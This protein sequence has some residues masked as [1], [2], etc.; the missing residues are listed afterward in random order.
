V[1]VLAAK[2]QKSSKR[3]DIVLGITNGGIVPAI[4]MGRELEIDYI[5]FIPVRNKQL[6]VHEMPRCTKIRSTLL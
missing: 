4:L 6:Q 2:I 3:Y 5:Q 1:R